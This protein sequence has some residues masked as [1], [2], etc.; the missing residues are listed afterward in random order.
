MPLSGRK[1]SSS[2]R[3]LAHST[4]R[5]PARPPP[6]QRH[7]L[8]FSLFHHFGHSGS[9]LL[10]DYAKLGATTGPFWFTVSSAWNVLLVVRTMVSYC[11]KDLSSTLT[12][13]NRPFHLI[14]SKVAHP[15]QSIL[16]HILVLSSYFLKLS[17]KILFV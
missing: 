13:T 15:T 2:V 8:L 3:S 4:P 11:N 1:S 7:H 9:S 16:Y 14:P 17:I 12:C 6:H 10:P 5:S